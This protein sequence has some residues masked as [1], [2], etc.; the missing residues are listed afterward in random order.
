MIARHIRQALQ[1]AGGKIDGPGGAAQLLGLHPNTLRTKMSSWEFH[2]VGEAGNIQEIRVA[3]FPA[4]KHT[5]ECRILWLGRQ[6]D[7]WQSSA[8][9]T[10]QEWMLLRSR[11]VSLTRGDGDSLIS[12]RF[13]LF[14]LR[15]A[16]GG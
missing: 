2:T 9:C 7:F 5:S 11:T 14:S 4:G 8:R 10:W 1:M 15:P 6:S 16:P 13:S 3:E 12:P